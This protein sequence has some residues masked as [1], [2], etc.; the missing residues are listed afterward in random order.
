[1]KNS[2]NIMMVIVVFYFTL[3]I[4]LYLTN[5]LRN[6]QFII[7]GRPAIHKI[8][9]VRLIKVKSKVNVIVAKILEEIR[10]IFILYVQLEDFLEKFCKLRRL[11]QS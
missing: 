3:F 4:Y 7:K 1:M 5:N 6:L 2:L 9:I 10:L 11:L 8:K